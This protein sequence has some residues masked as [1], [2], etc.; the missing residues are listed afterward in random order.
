MVDFLVQ[1]S[2]KRVEQAATQLLCTSSLHHTADDLTFSAVNQRAAQCER[3]EREAISTCEQC[4]ALYSIV[5]Y[6]PFSRQYHPRR[7]TLC[8]FCFLSHSFRA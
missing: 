8:L 7:T 4:G 6:T 3:E 5:A 1:S 2:L